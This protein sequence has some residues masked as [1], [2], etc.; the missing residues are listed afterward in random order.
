MSPFCDTVAQEYSELIE[1][2][3]LLMHISISIINNFGD[4][5]MGT[6]TFIQDET[7]L[8]L[9]LANES[10]LVVDFTASWCGP[11]KLVAPLMDQLADEYGDQIKVFKLDLDSNK[12]VAKRFSIKSI[13]A[14]LFFKDGELT[15]TL[16]GVKPYEDFSS[17][18]AGLL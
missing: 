15:E 18:V 2:G 7:E 14:I 12:P 5:P 9:L 6:V 13:P 4:T 3:W 10:L 17:V 1:I 8:D 11:C 16:I